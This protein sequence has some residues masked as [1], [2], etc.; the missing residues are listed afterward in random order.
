M[1][2]AHTQSERACR[3]FYTW[4]FVPGYAVHYTDRDA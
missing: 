4:R 2:K 3:T 1:R